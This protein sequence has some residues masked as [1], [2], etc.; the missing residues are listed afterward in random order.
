[1]TIDRKVQRR[2]I[3]LKDRFFIHICN[4][5]SKYPDQSFNANSNWPSSREWCAPQSIGKY[6]VTNFKTS[7]TYLHIL[8]KLCNNAIVMIS[9]HTKAVSPQNIF[10]QLVCLTMSKNIIKIKTRML[11]ASRI[12]FKK[13]RD[14]R[15]EKLE[16]V[17]RVKS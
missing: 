8:L 13:G 6:I 16:A 12:S 3:D 4:S 17:E 9:S 2:A 14:D 10:E 11:T 5:L 15:P 7:S 1:M